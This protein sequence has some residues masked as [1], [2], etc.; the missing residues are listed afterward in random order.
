MGPNRQTTQTHTHTHG[1]KRKRETRS[2]G[3]RCCRMNAHV[4]VPHPIYILSGFHHH[5]VFMLPKWFG[6]GNGFHAHWARYFL[7][8]IEVFYMLVRLNSPNFSNCSVNVSIDVR[9]LFLKCC[10]EWNWWDSTIQ[11]PTKGSEF[12]VHKVLRAKFLEFLFVLIWF[13]SRYPTEI[14]AIAKNHK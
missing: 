7:W 10:I 13:G 2:I 6:N 11:P 4:R 1:G 3:A 14:W 9:H 8:R 5:L 12:F